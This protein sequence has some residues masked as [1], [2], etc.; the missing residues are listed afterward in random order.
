M[1]RKTNRSQYANQQKFQ[2]YCFIDRNNRKIVN[3]TPEIKILI[4]PYDKKIWK[5]A[6]PEVKETFA[7]KL[8]LTNVGV[9]S[10]AKPNHVNPLMDHLRKYGNINNMT[11]LDGNGGMGGLSIILSHSFKSVD[12]VEITP[13][14]TKVIRN[15]AKVYGRNNIQAVQDDFMSF[16]EKTKNK[17]D[18]I[19]FD[20]PWGGRNYYKTKS[21]KLGFNNVNIWCIINKYIDK[22][23]KAFIIWAPFN[24]DIQDFIKNI[25]IN[26]I[27]IIR[28]P[29]SKHY[30]IIVSKEK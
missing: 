11:V 3:F 23:K 4:L 21:I 28:P 14:H 12:V 13:E 9:Y 24:F 18:F 25:R 22:A 16:I 15:N 6:F 20:L 1:K 8:L 27:R 26:N 2:P 29:K 17:Y 10:I 30:W 5:T 19:I 7:K